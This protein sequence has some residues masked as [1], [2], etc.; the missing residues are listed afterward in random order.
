MNIDAKL[1]ARDD[2]RIGDNAV[3]DERAEGVVE[4]EN[5]CACCS[6][7]DELFASVVRLTRGGTRDLDAI[8]VELSGVADPVAVRENWEEAARVGSSSRGTRARASALSLGLTLTLAPV[9][10]H[11]QSPQQGDPATRL[12][13]LR[14]TVTREFK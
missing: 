1:L 12:A 8:V 5:G 3:L 4:L 2:R 6:L 10:F 7:A 11:I 13:T 14:R 9:A